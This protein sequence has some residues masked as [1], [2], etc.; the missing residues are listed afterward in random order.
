M[1]NKILILS[2]I[3]LTSCNGNY[4]I[5]GMFYGQ[6]PRSDERFENSMTYNNSHGYPTIHTLSDTYKVY[7][8]TDMHVDSTWHNTTQWVTLLRNDTDCPFGIILG[9]II[10]AKNNF[11]NFDSALVFNPQT[12]KK[13]KPMFATVGNHDLYYGQWNDY[14][15]RWHTS[16]YY[17]TVNTPNFKDL[18]IC[19]DSGDGTWG[20]KQFDWL[21]DVLKNAQ[22]Q[23]FRHITIF[24][25]THIFKRDGSQGHTSNY[26][27]EETYE[28]LDL[29]SEY[30]VKWCVSGHCHNRDITDFKKTKYIIVDALEEHYPQPGYM[31]ATFSNI[32]TYEQRL[33]K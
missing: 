19:M 17:I 24:T 29:L 32:L 15:E 28:T 10:N 7:Y 14:L 30:N 2:L 21:K 3:L 13:D 23:N 6:S 9:D 22:S 4:D 12:Q 5:A 16:T 1:K 33:L 25:H 8:G 31:I 27:L 11:N 26:A 18:F 20:R